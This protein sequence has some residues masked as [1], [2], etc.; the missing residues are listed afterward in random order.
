MTYDFPV[1]GHLCAR[2]L[3]L[4]FEVHDEEESICDSRRQTIL[5]GGGGGCP[6]CLDHGTAH[7]TLLRM[8]SLCKISIDFSK[9]ISSLIH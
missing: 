5:V 1:N 9:A 2:T 7:N 8:F 6:Q 3:F 4:W